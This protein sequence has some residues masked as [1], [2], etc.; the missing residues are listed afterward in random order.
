MKVIRLDSL[1][2]YVL[3]LTTLSF[4][5]MGGREKGVGR[6]ENLNYEKQ[7]KKWGYYMYIV[8]DHIFCGKVLF[9]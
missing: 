3:E 5:K 8:Q 2:G 7:K 1:F 6:K 9:S 4:K